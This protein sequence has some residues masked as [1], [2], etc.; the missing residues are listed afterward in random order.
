M[1]SFLGVRF[2]RHNSRDANTRIEEV[3]WRNSSLGTQVFIERELIVIFA[4]A[5]RCGSRLLVRF[6]VANAPEM[7]ITDMDKTVIRR[8]LDLVSSS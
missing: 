6:S 4:C 5:V 7:A 1:R 8:D 3:G 2:V